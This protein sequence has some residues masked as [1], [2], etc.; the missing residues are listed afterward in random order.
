MEHELR[1]SFSELLGE[2]LSEEAE[3]KLRELLKRKM[4]GACSTLVRVLR[5]LEEHYGPE[6][7]DVVHDALMQRT[8]R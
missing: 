2:E 5:I 7:K 4:T 3:A 6:V 1:G 8:P